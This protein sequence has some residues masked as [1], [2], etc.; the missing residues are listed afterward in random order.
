MTKAYRK[1]I[2]EAFY[3]KYPMFDKQ[4]NWDVAILKAL[5]RKLNTSPEVIR[6][7][8]SGN[9]IVSARR[10]IIIESITG[11]SKVDLRPDIFG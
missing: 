1:E 4:G 6:K 5:A 11:V 10:A 8:A 9:C 3:L 7:I 2:R